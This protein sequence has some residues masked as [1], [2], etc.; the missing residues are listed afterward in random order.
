VVADRGD[1]LD[2]ERAALAAGTAALIL[3]WPGASGVVT[4]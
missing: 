1:D 4:A 3:G 2:E